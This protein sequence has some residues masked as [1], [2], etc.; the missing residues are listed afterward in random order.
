MVD[1]AVQIADTL[2]LQQW[3]WGGGKSSPFSKFGL[4]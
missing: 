4:E 1:G 3:L 2:M